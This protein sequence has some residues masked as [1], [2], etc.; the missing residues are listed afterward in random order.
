MMNLTLLA[1]ILGAYLLGSVS[2][3]ILVCRSFRLPDPRLGGSK[4]PGTT[5]VLRLG[6]KTPAAFTLLG[7]ALK[8]FLPVM[9]CSQISEVAP[10]LGYIALSAFL[11][12]LFPLFFQF[13]GGKGVATL[14]GASFALD[15]RLGLSFGLVWLS[16][17]TVTRYSSLSALMASLALPLVAHYLGES[18]LVLPLGIMVACIFIRHQTNIQKLLQGTESKIGKKAA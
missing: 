14:I 13:K 9:I 5:N 10:Y 15:W 12:H 16:V 17:A 8:A 4:N 7:D 1:S 3:A 18:A 6:G 2:S 11:G